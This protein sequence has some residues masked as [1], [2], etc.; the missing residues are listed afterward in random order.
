VWWRRLRLLTE[1][2]KGPGGMGR[3]ICADKLE[4]S[5]YQNGGFVGLA[6]LSI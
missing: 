2:V 6:D 1:V 3:F 5:A 4:I